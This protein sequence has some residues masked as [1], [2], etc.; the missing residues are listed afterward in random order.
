MVKAFWLPVRAMVSKLPAGLARR[1]LHGP[2]EPSAS[3]KRLQNVAIQSVKMPAR[4]YT[5]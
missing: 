5:E 3:R 1:S 4:N 2:A